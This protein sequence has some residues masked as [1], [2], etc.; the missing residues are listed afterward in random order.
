[1]EGGVH[2]AGPIYWTFGAATPRLVTTLTISM[3]W[4]QTLNFAVALLAA[5]WAMR[6]VRKPRGWLG[7]RIARAMN[8]THAS[9]TE[10]GLGQVKVA[11]DA[12][13]LDVGC[14]GGSTV[15][16]LSAL[17]PEGRVA[18]LDFATGSVAVSRD[19]NAKEIAAGRVIIVRGSVAALPFA[20]AA[21]DL[22]TA[23]ETHYYWPDL[24]ANVREVRRVLKPGGTFLLIAET[25]K[26]GPM[27]RLYGGVM[28]LLGAAF[29]SDA[30]HRDLLRGA[31][32]GEVET[33]H[34]KGKDWICAR[35]IGGSAGR[36]A[37]RT[38][39]T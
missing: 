5:A 22:V 31:G 29:L 26:D 2:P 32:F 33:L 16:R 37:C 38:T 36:E 15:R 35:G 7:R 28:P 4:Q 9:M 20:D 13:I 39:A 27:G 11:K 17:A 14:G 1:M 19:I 12:V 6:M 30:E 3:A 24:A 23:V 8:V 21:F 34:L 10:W 25:Y 18:G